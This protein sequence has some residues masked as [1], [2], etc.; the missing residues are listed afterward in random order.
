MVNLRLFWKYSAPSVPRSNTTFT[1]RAP[2]M[3]V[4]SGS[5][6]SAW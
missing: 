4:S 1:E 2:G 6:D 3:L 5:D